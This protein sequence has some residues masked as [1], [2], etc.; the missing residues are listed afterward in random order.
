[1]ASYDPSEFPRASTVGGLPAPGG[2]SA[3]ISDVTEAPAKDTA[4]EADRKP[5][6]W[7]RFVGAFKGGQVD[8]RD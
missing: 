8:K 2:A 3:V 4:A 5:G 7:S 1:M 6:F